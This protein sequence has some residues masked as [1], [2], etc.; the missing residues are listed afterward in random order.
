M[1]SACTSTGYKKLDIAPESMNK[2][3]DIG[4]NIKV[5]TKNFIYL[6][7]VTGY[8]DNIL[9]IGTDKFDGREVRIPFDDIIEIGKVDIEYHS[10]RTTRS[11]SI[12]DYIL[13]GVVKTTLFISFIAIFAIAA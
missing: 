12:G 9:V 10:T 6:I 8:E 11:R 4:S 3:I 2:S 13:E 1:V 5:E 7:T